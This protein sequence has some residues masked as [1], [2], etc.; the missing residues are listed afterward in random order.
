MQHITHHLFILPAI[1]TV[2]ETTPSSHHDVTTISLHLAYQCN[3]VWNSLMLT[4][5]CNTISIHFACHSNCVWGIFV[6]TSWCNTISIHLAMAA[7]EMSILQPQI[8]LG[9][10]PVRST[11]KQHANIFLTQKTGYSSC[12]PAKTHP[13]DWLFILL[14][15]QTSPKG[16][17][18]HTVAKPNLTQRTSYSSCC[19][20]KPHP[21]D[22]PWCN[23]LWLTGLKAPT[24]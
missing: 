5:W 13:K 7:R 22:Q 17:V 10:C 19:P 23:P 2:Y 16:L 6:F 9:S 12:C 14:P 8:N 24:N 20:A 3:C 21:K 11:R 18:I 15:S 1:V 4:S